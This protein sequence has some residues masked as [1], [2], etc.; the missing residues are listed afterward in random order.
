MPINTPINQKATQVSQ[1]AAC[2]LGISAAQVLS[3]SS[4]SDSASEVDQDDELAERDQ[5]QKLDEDDVD[6]QFCPTT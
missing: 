6:T 3:S 4:S 1:V 2:P 5:L